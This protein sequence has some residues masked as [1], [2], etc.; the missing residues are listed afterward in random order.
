[1]YAQVSAQQLGIQRNDAGAAPDNDKHTSE[2]DGR[3]VG[4]SSRAQHNR[5][6]EAEE[7]RTP[8]IP[9]TKHVTP[10]TRQQNLRHLDTNLLQV[11]FLQ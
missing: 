10:F 2:H 4:G 5:Q 9:V 8:Q 3:L 1:M 6:G 7:Q 11:T